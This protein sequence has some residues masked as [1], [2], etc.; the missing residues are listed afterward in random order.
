MTMIVAGVDLMARPKA[1]RTGKPQPDPAEE[2]PTIINLKGSPEYVEWLDGIHK[3]THL[4]K[5]TIIRLAL[6]EWAE[7]HGHPSPPER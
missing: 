7:R 5:S 6:A 2:R 4:Q 1:K 3:K